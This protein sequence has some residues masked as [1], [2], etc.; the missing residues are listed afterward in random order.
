MGGMHARARA[1]VWREGA[2]DWMIIRFYDW[3]G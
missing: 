2:S 1:S 3:A